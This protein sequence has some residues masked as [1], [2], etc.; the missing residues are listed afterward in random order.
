MPKRFLFKTRYVDYQVVIDPGVA[1]VP[2]SYV[3]NLM[4]LRDPDVT[5]A[6]H[7]P[8]GF[9]EMMVMY[10]YYTVIGARVRI[11]AWNGDT[12]DSQ[13]IA[14]FIKNSTTAISTTALFETAMETNAGRYTLLG[15][16]TG[17]PNNKTLSIN[18]SSRRF[19]GV[20]NIIDNDVYRGTT[21]SDPTDNAYLHIVGIPQTSSDSNSIRC[22]VMI[23]YIALLTEP[24]QLPSS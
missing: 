7:Q 6:G 20:K 8:I 2:S 9:D 11:D 24:L 16:N 13:V 12:S 14:A 15:S 23:E 17:G 10:K 1:G 5:G 4:S 3:F 21:A 19:F 22:T 18:F